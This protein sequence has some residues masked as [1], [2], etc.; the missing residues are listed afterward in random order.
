[1]EFLALLD[2]IRKATFKSSTIIS[3]FQKVGLI[4]FNPKVVYE[5]MKEFTALEPMTLS[6]NLEFN[7]TECYTPINNSRLIDK[8][9]KYID[10]R[11]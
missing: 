7:F 9:S 5:K 1:M 11:I 8:Y 6:R 3:S 4:P 2:G 10:L